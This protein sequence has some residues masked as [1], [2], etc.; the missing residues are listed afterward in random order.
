MQYPLCRQA[1]AD[2]DPLSQNW[3]AVLERS[4]LGIFDELAP[5]HGALS[6]VQRVVEGRRFLV[7]T[8]LGYG[9]RGIEV[10]KNLQLP[11]P[12]NGKAKKTTRSKVDDGV[13][14]TADASGANRPPLVG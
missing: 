1:F 8:L 7:R 13:K 6:E 4:A 10:F 3:R 11:V 9:Q 12:E 14:R 2:A 5:M